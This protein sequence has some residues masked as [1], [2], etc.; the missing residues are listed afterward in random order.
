VN[1]AASFYIGLADAYEANQKR[2]QILIVWLVPV[3]GAIGLS[4]FLYKDRSASKKQYQKGNDTSF[5]N[6]DA[7]NHYRGSEHRGG[8]EKY[9]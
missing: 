1:I 5:T 4:Y 2:L 6:N 3:F 8:R 7:I 9:Y